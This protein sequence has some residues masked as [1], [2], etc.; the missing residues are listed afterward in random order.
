M[1]MLLP[2]LALCLLTSGVARAEDDEDDPK[3]AK[4]RAAAKPKAPPA[5]PAEKPAVKAAP[6]TKVAA[7]S[8]ISNEDGPPP[9]V[10][11]PAV[12]PPKS[13]EP[14]AKAVVHEPAPP[15]RPRAAAEP[16]PAKKPAPA[17]PATPRASA[18]PPPPHSA[19]SV[20]SPAEP[21][22]PPTPGARPVR[23]RLVDGSTVIGQVRAEQPESLVIDCALGQ[24][25]IPRSRIATIAYDGA[26]GIGQKR[27]P[28]Q[29]LDDDLP[30]KKRPAP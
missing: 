22:A 29:Q 21:A 6:A 16:A 7:P 1:K 5:P 8:K 27:A 25:A 20:A 18:L 28:V 3:A 14:P 10:R 19:S 15:A 2:L 24:L 4:V 13:A 9:P 26:A 12:T 11:K 30:A 23:V 17:E